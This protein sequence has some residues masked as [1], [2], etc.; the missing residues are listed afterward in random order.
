[1]YLLEACCR[2][3]QACI[4]GRYLLQVLSADKRIYGLGCGK[5]YPVCLFWFQ[6]LLDGLCN[7]VSGAGTCMGGRLLC[8]RP[9]YRL[10][11]P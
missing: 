11:L 6:A 10:G 2:L 1:M 8:F 5:Q 9:C 7:C 3:Q 4:V